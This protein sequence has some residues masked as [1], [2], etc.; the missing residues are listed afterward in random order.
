MVN[1]LEIEIF[2]RIVL[3]SVLGGIIGLDRER[4]SHPAG[5]RTNILVCVGACLMTAVSVHGFAEYGTVKDPA[6]LSAQIVSG[7]GFLGA[8]VILHKGVSVR[9]LTTAASMWTVAGIGIAVGVGMMKLATATTIL[10]MVV[11]ASSRFLEGRLKSKKHAVLQVYMIK[12]DETMIALK[13]FLS[14]NLISSKTF[15]I[16]YSGDVYIVFEINISS[17]KMEIG[18][19]IEELKHITGITEVVRT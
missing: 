5:F 3:A 9:G 8:G 6:R 18:V 10:V 7:I 13:R 17:P 11:L 14:K 12:N 15:D 2:L 4:G 1:A 16:I 19:V